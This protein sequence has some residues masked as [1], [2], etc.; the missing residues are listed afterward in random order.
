[1]HNPFGSFSTSA[2]LTFE[3]DNSLFILVLGMCVCV[4]GVCVAGTGG[5]LSCTLWNV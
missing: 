3:P 4:R 5:G 2:L 1:M